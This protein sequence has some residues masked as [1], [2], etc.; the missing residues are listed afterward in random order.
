[1]PFS[2]LCSGEKDLEVAIFTQLGSL[3]LPKHRR[4][5]QNVYRCPSLSPV[6]KFGSF[7]LWMVASVFFVGANF[8]NLATKKESLANPTKGFLRFKKNSPYPDKKKFRSRQI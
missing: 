3:R 1:M 5:L 6:A 2:S 4:I 8:R 7:L